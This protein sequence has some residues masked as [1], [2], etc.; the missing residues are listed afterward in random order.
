[1]AA[2]ILIVEDDTDIRE[3]IAEALA[4]EGYDVEQARD[5]VDALRIAYARAPDLIVLDL[6]MPRMDGWTF[7]CAQRADDRVA[8]IPVLIASATTVDNSL[9]G[10]AEVL[11]KPFTLDALYE[12]VSRL[13]AHH[14]PTSTASSW[15]P[16]PESRCT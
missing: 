9:L 15:H 5:G 16:S 14:H 8:Q 13:T 4:M 1:M 10:A 3:V 6:M 12:A 2:R 11:R 7:R